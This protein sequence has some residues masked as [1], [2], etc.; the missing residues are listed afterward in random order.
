MKLKTM[1]AIAAVTYGACAVAHDLDTSVSNEFWCCWLHK[2]D[3]VNTQGNIL[4]AA[5]SST[6]FT[7]QSGILD[8]LLTNP[9]GLL[10]ILK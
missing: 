7:E 3:V 9:W 8:R 2:N 6:E 5:F 4:P 10:M 1:V